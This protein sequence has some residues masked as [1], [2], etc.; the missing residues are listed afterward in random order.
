MMNLKFYPALVV[1]SR[2][3]KDGSP[4]TVRFTGRMYADE[5][6]AKSD[7]GRDFIRLCDPGQLVS[8]DPDTGDLK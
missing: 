7:H 1:Y 2:N 6:D 5:E 4:K 3:K 8:Y